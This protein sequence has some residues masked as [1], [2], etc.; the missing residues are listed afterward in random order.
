M[1][2][3]SATRNKLEIDRARL[4]AERQKLVGE[5]GRLRKTAAVALARGRAPR[6][7]PPRRRRAPPRRSLLRR[8]WPWPGGPARRRP[9]PRCSTRP[10]SITLRAPS[11]MQRIDFVDEPARASVIIDLDEPSS[12]RILRAG[13][14]AG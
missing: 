9:P 3:I 5:L 6:R 2:E 13:A 14:A 7:R 10:F 1:A 11:R 12:F 8:R 4:E